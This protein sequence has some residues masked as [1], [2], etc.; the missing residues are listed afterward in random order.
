M[1]R[2]HGLFPIAFLAACSSVD[3]GPRTTADRPAAEMRVIRLQ[4]T[5]GEEIATTLRTTLRQRLAARQQAGGYSDG[6]E[7]V[8]AAHAESNSLLVSAAADP[9]AEIVEWVANLDVK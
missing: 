1:H 5:V 8:V 2:A 9:M 4:H 7:I 3:S 6:G